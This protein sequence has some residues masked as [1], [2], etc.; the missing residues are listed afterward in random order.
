MTQEKLS[1]IRTG[2]WVS[3]TTPNDERII[4][5]V[6]AGPDANGKVT[7]FVTSSD[8][9]EAVGRL[10]QCNPGKI[11]AMSVQEPYLEEELTGLIDLALQTRDEAWFREI[12]GVMLA[13]RER[14]R[15]ISRNE[16]GQTRK[17]RIFID[18]I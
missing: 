16:A 12:T 13:G 6:E 1:P 10:V 4:G 18:N 2:D 9:Q 15:T 3:G 14:K 11:S 8:R 17:R 7:V 5:Y